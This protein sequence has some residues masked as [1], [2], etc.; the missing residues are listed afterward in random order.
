MFSASRVFLLAAKLAFGTRSIFTGFKTIAFGL[1]FDF[2][3]MGFFTGRR[4][5]LSIYKI[6]SYIIWLF[7][8]P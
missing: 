6:E 5:F 1:F 2:Y 7:R 3:A 8:E 4:H